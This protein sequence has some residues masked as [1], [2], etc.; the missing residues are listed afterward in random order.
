[1]ASEGSGWWHQHAALK[2]PQDT[3]HSPL[4]VP[5]TRGHGAWHTLK[6]FSRPR[7]LTGPADRLPP[8]ERHTH[9]PHTRHARLTQAPTCSHQPVVVESPLSGWSTY[10][11]T[12]T[13]VY[14]SSRLTH[15]RLGLPVD[16][17][18]FL[19]H[20]IHRVLSVCSLYTHTYTYTYT[21]IPDTGRPNHLLN[22]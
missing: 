7:E 3:G 1:M 14:Q 16:L 9:A 18:P 5:D 2:C 22:T 10:T 8:R 6:T 13:Q 12:H 17:F 11:Q 19:F 20:I 4:S 21:C 15:G